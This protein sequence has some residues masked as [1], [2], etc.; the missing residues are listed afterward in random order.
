MKKPQQNF[1]DILIKAQ[2]T[3]PLYLKTIWLFTYSDMKTIMFPQSIFGAITAY[4]ACMFGQPHVSHGTIGWLLVR[5]PLALF[6]TWSNLLPFNIFNQFSEEAIEEDRI[7]KPWRPLPSGMISRE[8]AASIMWKHYVAAIIISSNIGGLRQTLSLIFLGTWYNACGGADKSFIIRN[9]INAAGI[10]SFATGA[11]EVALGNT[12]LMNEP[13][14]QWMSI[15]ASV[16]FTTVQTQDLYDMEGDSIRNRK[17]MPLVIGDS[18]TRWY[19]ALTISIFSVVCPA[20]WSMRWYGF[21]TPLLLGAFITTRTL[22]WRTPKA[23]KR[24]FQIWNAWLVS[25]YFLPVVRYLDIGCLT[26]RSS[27]P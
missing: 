14:I 17:T 13:S 25:I 8:Q 6:W 19:T 3:T 4:A 26:T 21:V 2:V 5:Y 16:I 24:T 9:L 22:K 11:M 23:D 27:H 18:W 7:N 1:Y 15:L 10:L 20:Y 12:L